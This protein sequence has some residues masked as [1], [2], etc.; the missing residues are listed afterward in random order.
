MILPLPLYII[1]LLNIRFNSNDLL[2]SVLPLTYI[3][4]G[5]VSGERLY[6]SKSGTGADSNIIILKIL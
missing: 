6:G 4:L 3:E 1:R 2:T 5:C